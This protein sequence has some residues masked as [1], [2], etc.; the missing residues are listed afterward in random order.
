MVRKL[1]RLGRDQRGI[2]GLET[3]II[4]IAFVVVAAVFA[5]TAL[6]AGL[7]STQKSSEAIYAGLKETQSTLEL[8]GGVIAYWA[9]ISG[10]EVVGKVEFTVGLVAGG[11]PID[12]TAPYTVAGAAGSETLSAE[13]AGPTVIGF[14]DA[15]VKVNECAWTVT[16]VG[17]NDGDVLLESTE[18]AV[19]TVW[20]HTVSAGTWAAGTD[21]F[22]AANYVQTKAE[23]RMEVKPSAGATLPIERTTPANLDTV[24]DLH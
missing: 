14:N 12:L 22:L 8:R 17:E 15:N 20:L 2:T 4:L 11:E 13:T 6:S 19:I 1:S 7:F 23:F 24:M 10:T 9:N 3:A 5:Y 21:P 18:K 16:W